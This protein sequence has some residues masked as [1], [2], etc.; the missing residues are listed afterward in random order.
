[1]ATR[2]NLTVDRQGRMSVGKLG[3]REGHVVAESLPGD[4]GW[5]IRAAKLYTEAEID[6]LSAMDGAEL[7]ERGLEDLEHGRTG[8]AFRR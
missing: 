6:I 7:V 1:M 4:A 2:I 3:L 5:I 8:P